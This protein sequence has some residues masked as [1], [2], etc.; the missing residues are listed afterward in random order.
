MIAKNLLY[1][2]YFGSAVVVGPVCENNTDLI[3][4]MLMLISVV[5]TVVSEF[6]VITLKFSDKSSKLF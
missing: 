2:G 3:A 6:S 1:F 4:F 5:P